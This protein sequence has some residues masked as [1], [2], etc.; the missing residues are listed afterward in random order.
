M[1]QLLGGK[2]DHEQSGIIYR[3]FGPHVTLSLALRA[4]GLKGAESADV[5]A[6]Q[7]FFT[8]KR[9]WEEEDRRRAGAHDATPT[10]LQAQWAAGAVTMPAVAP[11][12]P[13]APASMPADSPDPPD[14]NL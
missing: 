3:A 7:L 12:P 1:L 6:I 11:A 5:K 2:S 13:A 4:S 10:T 8:E 9:Q 14:H